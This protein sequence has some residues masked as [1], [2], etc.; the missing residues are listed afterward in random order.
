MRV[1]LEAQEQLPEDSTEEADF[2]RIDVTDKSE[3]ERKEILSALREQFADKS[4]V[5][6]YHLCRHDEGG[7]CEIKVVEE[8]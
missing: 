7:A 5:I 4:Y 2:V 3:A 6:Q 8:K 1:Y